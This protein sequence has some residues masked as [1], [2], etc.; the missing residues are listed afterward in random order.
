MNRLSLAMEMIQFQNDAFFK[1]LTNAY[2]AL[3]E[4]DAKEI[5]DSKENDLLSSIVKHH[6]GIKM[7]FQLAN[8]EPS[9]EIPNVNRN[10]PLVSDFI[11]NFMN[12]ADGRAMIKNADGV[13]TGKV[14]LMTGKVSGVFS[15]LNIVQNMPIKMIKDKKYSSEELAAISLHEVGHILIYFEFLSRVMTTNQVLAGVSRCLDKSVGAPERVIMMTDIKNKLKIDI[16]VEDAAKTNNEQVIQVMILNRQ[17]QRAR[18]ELGTNIYDAN[19]WEQLADQYAA[20]N[21]AGRYL[22]TALDKLHRSHF[23][24]S[25]RTTPVFLAYE[26][27]KLVVLFGGIAM[28]GMGNLLGFIW[29]IMT[30]MDDLDDGTYD[31]PG[32]RLRRVRNEM[33]QNLKEPD[34]SK[35]DAQRIREDIVI[36]DDILSKINDRRQLTSFIWGFVSPTQKKRLSAEAMQQELEAMV[37]N[38]LFVR[39]KE[40]QL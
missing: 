33:V 21:G 5:P 35:E 4:M 1:E 37:A 15:T 3:R 8:I 2:A 30:S 26:A 36:V 7:D 16:D 23:N 29:N 20:R 39:A 14:N 32:V 18:S 22:V 34:L 27:L 24:I 40:L 6:T 11:K 28:P 9:V 38:D 25:F 19:N 12:D 17:I 13:A 10:N 31:R